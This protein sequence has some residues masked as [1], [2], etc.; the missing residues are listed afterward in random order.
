MTV[1]SKWHHT[2][3]LFH[4]DNDNSFFSELIWSFVRRKTEL[5]RPSKQHRGRGNN[6]VEFCGF[7]WS[8]LQPFPFFFCDLCYLR[9]SPV[10]ERC[11]TTDRF[12]P[13]F[14]L[15][16]MINL[17]F[18][19][20]EWFESYVRKNLPSWFI[21]IWIKDNP[22]MNQELLEKTLSCSRDMGLGQQ[23]SINSVGMDVEIWKVLPIVYV[24]LK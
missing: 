13:P 22:E 23:K 7:L 24:L 20:I 15:I 5:L 16:S 12:L 2:C 4:N 14:P 10:L 11:F 1:L 6:F 19:I 3:I 8:S 21:Y 18:R 17:P 9:S